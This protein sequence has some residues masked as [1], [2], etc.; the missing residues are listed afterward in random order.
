MASSQQLLT[1]STTVLHPWPANMPA[2]EVVEFNGQE[3]YSTFDTYLRELGTAWVSPDSVVYK[4]GRLIR[5]SLPSQDLA[6]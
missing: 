4:N 3:A 6:S 2:D 5:E 1:A